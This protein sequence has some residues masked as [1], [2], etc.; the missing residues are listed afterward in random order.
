MSVDKPKPKRPPV[1]LPQRPPSPRLLRYLWELDQVTLLH[2]AGPRF[3]SKY[4]PGRTAIKTKAAR[5]GAP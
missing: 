4:R 5:R 3:R 2:A 1:V